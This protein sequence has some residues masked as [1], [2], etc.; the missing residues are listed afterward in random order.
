[1]LDVTQSREL[2]ATIYALRQARR[3]IR[4][5]INK[6]TRNRLKPLWIIASG[7]LFGAL[8]AGAAGMQRDAGVPAVIVYVIEAGIIISLLLIDARQRARLARA[9][10]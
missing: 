9:A 7:I 8:E 4:L 3:D 5:D 2:Q 1:M 10:A 6:T